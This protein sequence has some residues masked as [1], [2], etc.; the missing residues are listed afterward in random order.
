L[1][2]AVVFAVAVLAEGATP[3]ATGG[4]HTG[5]TPK[6]KTAKA[7]TYIVVEVKNMQGDISFEAIP[8]K[9]LPD[10]IKKCQTDYVE[11]MKQWTK[12]KADAKKKGEKF[13]EKKPVEP[14]VKRVGT[15]LFKEQDK[16]TA[17]ADKLQQ[18]YD[19]MKKKAEEKKLELEKAKTTDTK[20]ETPAPPAGGAAE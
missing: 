20:T 15:T 14:W 13:E 18:Q 8:S 12:D 19:E 2:A 17:Y 10:R 11:A 7:V 1:A 4:T 16:A 6:D 5:T 9:D 3:G